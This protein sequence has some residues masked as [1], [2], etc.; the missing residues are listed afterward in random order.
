MKKSYLQCL[1]LLAITILAS[2]Q[3]HAQ[4]LGFE[5]T[6]AA[7]PPTN[8]TAVSGTWSVNTSIVRTGTQSMAITDPA[9][10]GTTIGTT[11]PFVN[12]TA[13]GYLITIGWGRA[14]NATNA[15]FHL[16][17]RTGTTNTV[18]PNITTTGQAPNLND[19]NWTRITS[20]SVSGTLA[21]GSYGASLRAFRSATSPSTTIY[22]DDIITYASASNV[23]DLTAPN[24]VIGVTNASNNLSW[25]NGVDIGSPASG[26][27]GVV[28]IRADGAL[29]PAPT[30]NDQAMYNPVTGAA[31]VGSF[32]QNSTTWTVVANISGSATTSFNDVSAVAGPY[33]YF[34]FL[35]DVAFNYSAGVTSSIAGPCT[36]PP[37]AGVATVNPATLVCPG[38]QVVLNTSGNSSGTGQTFQWESAATAGGVYSP[39]N[40]PSSSS[41]LLLNAPTVTMFYRCAITCGGNTQYTTPATI[42][43]LPAFAGTYTINSAQAT[44]GN[45]YQTFGAAVAAITSCGIAGPVVFNVAAGSGPYNEQVL[46]AAIGGSSAFNTVTFDGNGT[47]LSFLSANTNERAGFKL[48]GARFV[49]IN[50]MII[51]A[52]GTTTMEYGYGVQMLNNADS[53]T[54]KNCTININQT[55]T[56]TSNY[57]GIVI[58]SSATGITTLGSSLCDG[59]TIVA[60]TINGG[61]AGVAMV[62]NGVNSMINDNRIVNNTIKDFYEYGVYI[63]GNNNAVIEGNNI[64]R[65]NRTA[66]TTYRGVGLNGISLNSKVFKNRLHNPFGASSNS[67]AAAFMIFLTACNAT[68]GNENIISNNLM[69]DHI[70]STGNHNGILNNIS[71]NVKIYH[72]TI[73]LNDV[74]ATCSTCA[75]R[76]IYQQ[77]TAPTGLDVR[78]NIVVI[79]QGGD[80]PKQAIF[81]ETDNVSSYILN[82][83][84]Y[85]ITSTGGA[86]NEIAR[87]GG[88]SSVPAAGTGFTT[89]GSWQ[90]SSGMEALSRYDDPFFVSPGTGNFTPAAGNINDIGTPVGIT[91]DVI[92]AVRNG[93][94]P[95]A[96]AYEFAT[97]ACIA[98]PAAGTA[99]SNFALPVCNGR[100]VALN[101]TGLSNGSGQSYEWFMSATING[102]YT[103]VSTASA[104]PGFAI[105]PTTS[106]YYKAAVTCS[107]VTQFSLPVFVEVASP[108]TGTFTINSAAATGG[109][110]FQTFADAVNAMSCGVAGPV[111]FNVAAGTYNEQV[112][113]PAIAGTSATNRI[114]FNG[115][116]ATV[117][118]LSSNTNERGIIKLNGTDYVTIDNFVI[119]ATGT[120]ATEYGYGVHLLNNADNNTISNCTITLTSTPVTVASTAYAG[121]VVNTT[122]TGTPT[123]AGNSDCDNNSFVSN[124]ITGGYSGISIV[125]NGTTN[126]VIGNV[127]KNNTITDFYLYGIYLNGNTNVL[128][129]GNE[130]SRP[131]R[132]SVSTFNGIFL[133][134][135]VTASIIT[136]NK[137]HDPF[138]GNTTS[139]SIAYGIY[140]STDGTLEKPN[141]FSNNMIYAFNSSGTQYGLYNTTSPYAKY[142]FNSILLDGPTTAS[143]TYDTRGIYQTGSA[144]GIEFK[145]NIVHITRQCIGDNHCIYMAT[146]A[147]NFVSDYNDFFITTTSGVLNNVGFYNAIQSPTLA[148]WITNSVSRDANSLSVDPIFITATDLHLQVGSTL[149]DRGVPVPEISIDIDGT[150][151][152]PTPVIGADEFGALPATIYVFTGNGN[153]NVA[154]NWNNNIIPPSPLPAGSQIYINP[155]GSATLNVPVTIATGAK[156]TVVAGK[157]FI[158]QGNLTLQ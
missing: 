30:L 31:G 147:T 64:S 133:T 113:I 153:W 123:T 34:I 11:N 126:A 129:E 136:R 75:A 88:S 17:Y 104:N 63:N 102:T 86:Y 7:T 128:V 44:G 49:A 127:V 74:A 56:S 119:Q 72:N 26:V 50:N 91:T 82:N 122:A 9:T 12:T 22:I 77:G 154:A 69:Y 23:P 149:K 134:T 158:V 67:T 37:T 68:V 14:S 94:N 5:A 47:T 99:T 131:I 29:L 145:N 25:T 137:I 151:R 78:N 35:R 79:S 59:N 132:T 76:G 152:S 45:N 20:A 96:G 43:V 51:T 10:S 19:V 32:M 89:I 21:A 142:Y 83:N 66:V 156:I 138:T 110:N 60:N 150:V 62:A 2:V 42:M 106:A 117:S 85:N 40:A 39:I 18:N 130:I 135:G 6:P 36:S 92:N 157:P 143:A 112:I 121:I 97:L 54:I 80:A 118:F 125:G 107:E 87:I 103:S 41:S 141:V 53:N 95:D 70:G 90:A 52:T 65:P 71:S 109:T 33:T 3:L 100:A 61:Y 57:A 155:S 58:N 120:T 124:T 81:F 111:T 46:I 8:W 27:G 116:G 48:N 148:N 84:V 38:T 4:N 15:L 105:N 144:A 101:L 108:F 140:S 115:N 28:I 55:S 98:P 146:A 93:T 13:P 1:S 73:Y 114:L 139:I 16:G 24:P